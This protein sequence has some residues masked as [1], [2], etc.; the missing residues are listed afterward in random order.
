MK[1]TRLPEDT[2]KELQ[3]NAG[4]L[5]DSFT[6]ATGAIGELLGATTGG[7]SF[8]ATPTY[9]D[10]GDD[11]DNCPKN[12]KELKKLDSWEAKMSGTYLTTTAKSARSLLGAADIDSTDETHVKPRNTLEASDFGDIWWV[13]DYSDM[14]GENNGG[15]CAIHLISALSTGG[16]QVKSSD[17]CKGQFAFEYTAHYSLADQ[18]L[19]P[20]EI[21][22]KAGEAE[23]AN[24][25]G[26]QADTE[27]V[28]NKEQVADESTKS[29]E[30]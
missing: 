28:V 5:V 20:F 19:V 29:V 2:F 27:T 15:F 12:V 7:C 17:K 4:I 8:T 9:T 21:Y 24:V 25:S 11:I 16:Y 14:N 3:M 18:N 13:G 22:V 26:E 10:L 23:T 30:K 6:P 1:F